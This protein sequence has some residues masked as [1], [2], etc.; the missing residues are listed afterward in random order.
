MRMFRVVVL[1]ISVLLASGLPV[2]A[3]QKSPP[4][5][6]SLLSF[7]LTP[8]FSIPVGGDASVFNIGGGGVLSG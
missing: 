7:S 2:S 1:I 5:S 3:Q 6:A 4:K 8:D